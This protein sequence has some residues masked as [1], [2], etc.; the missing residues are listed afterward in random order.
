MI[1]RICLHNFK[2]FDELGVELAPV[3]L[4][5][6]PNNSGKSSIIAAIRLLAQTSISSDLQVALLLDGMM[7][8]FGTYKDVVYGN[9]RGRPFEI[10]LSIP[11][12]PPVLDEEKK[13][14]TWSNDQG[15]ILKFKSEYKYRTR[16]RELILKSVEIV[17]NGKVLLVTEY[18]KDSERQLIEKIG[19]TPVPST[20][21]SPLSKMLRM[22]HFLPSYFFYR[23]RTEVESGILKDFLTD[24]INKLIELTNMTTRR[25][26]AALERVEY[27]GSMRMPPSRTYLYSGEKR[28]RIGSTGE[29]AA[30]ILAMDTTRGGGRSQ[31]ITKQVSQWLSK[32]GIA[33]DLKIEQISDRHFEIRVQHPKTRE[34]QNL[35]DVGQG[36]SQILPVLIGGYNLSA[37]ST[38]MIEEPEIHLH[39]SAQADLGDFFLD[40]YEKGIQTII[41]THSEHI[42]LRLLQHIANGAIPA[43]HIRFYYVYAKDNKKEVKLL[44]V[45]NRGI[46]KE[47]WPEGFF[48]ERLVEAKKLARLRMKV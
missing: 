3:T 13:R 9:H 10:T 11:L 38:Y 5:L 39:P 37:G 16:R 40:L 4:L 34:Y 26:S 29:N 17:R 21:K 2:A 25:I 48:P 30:G 36:N 14:H 42:I 24:D 15:D 31:N 8:D 27:I 41:E 35:A 19:E 33:S 22:I 12:S 46:F 43:E 47:E 28:G 32:A 1:S 7:G 6:G 44:T 18:S 23:T 20:I 45:D